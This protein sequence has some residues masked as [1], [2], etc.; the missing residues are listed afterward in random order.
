MRRTWLTTDDRR[1]LYVNRDRAASERLIRN[2]EKQG[3]KA[4]MLTVDAP[5]AGNRELDR[6]TKGFTVGP[7]HGKT[8]PEG[9]GVALVSGVLLVIVHR[10]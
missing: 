1:Q 6:R 10:I 9:G 7:A 4:I 2:L 8:G 3:F 5:I